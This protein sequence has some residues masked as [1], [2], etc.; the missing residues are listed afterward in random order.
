MQSK[1]TFLKS[2]AALGAIPLGAA[3][4]PNQQAQA[5]GRFPNFMLRTQ[6]GKPVQFYDDC[7]KGK[8]VV[9]SMMYTNCAG[10]CP[11]NTANLKAVREEL[12]NRVGRDIFIYSLT[13]QP[14]ID[15]PQDLMAYARR[16]Q[17]EGPG[18][19]FLTGKPD[20]ME[21]LRKKLGFFDSDPELDRDITRHS[22]V[23]RI[24]SERKDRWLMMPALTKANQIAYE[25]RNLSL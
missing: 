13:L 16:Y 2:V 4:A 1:R 15:R 22:G 17:I 9:L 14:Q 19:T 5:A 8:L 24:G 10:I 7:I 3:A 18:W 6:A 21:I 11:P 23:L 12:G 25:V 20:E